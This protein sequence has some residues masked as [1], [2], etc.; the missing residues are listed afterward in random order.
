MQTTSWEL[1]RRWRQQIS[2]RN[3]LRRTLREAAAVGFLADRWRPTQFI[4]IGQLTTL[5]V[6]DERTRNGALVI[7]VIGFRPAVTETGVHWMP[8]NNMVLRKNLGL[9]PRPFAKGSIIDLRSRELLGLALRLDHRIQQSQRH[10]RRIEQT[11]LRMPRVW[12]GFRRSVVDSVTPQGPSFAALCN[13]F[14]LP[15]TAMAAKFKREHEGLVLLPADWTLEDL[16][17]A[18]AVFAE[19]AGMARRQAVTTQE[20]VMHVRPNG[21]VGAVP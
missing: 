21:D 3:P 2:W 10:P 5:A 11:E 8:S 18:T 16:G 20:V 19:V 17:R 6:Y 7:R 13:K 4:Q 15:P 1:Q 9:R 12:A 14:D